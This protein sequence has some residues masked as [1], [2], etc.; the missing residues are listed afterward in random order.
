MKR[1]ITIRRR[2]ESFGRLL[3]TNGVLVTLL[4]FLAIIAGSSQ[5]LRGSLLEGVTVSSLS[6]SSSSVAPLSP[7]RTCSATGSIFQDIW[8]FSTLE[9]TFR[10]QMAA[11]TNERIELLSGPSKWSCLKDQE[12]AMPAL[13]QMAKSLPGWYVQEQ[14]PVPQGTLT[15]TMLR[16]VIWNAF[17]S[18]VTEFERVYECRLGEIASRGSIVVMDNLDYDRT[19]ATGRPTTFC[20]TE[21][22]GTSGGCVRKEEGTACSTV[23]TT[24]PQCENQCSVLIDSYQMATRL[25]PLVERMETE[26][27]HVRIAL[28]RTLATLRS[29]ETNFAIAR[30]LNCYE[31]ASVDLQNE[32]S[33]L[34]DAGSCLPRMWDIVTSLHDRKVTK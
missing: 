4:T 15:R 12:P 32:L 28:Q 17:S 29:F 34:S 18:I 10:E 26:R 19:D 9:S 20:C 30:Q 33:L 13:T 8:N 7:L 14:Y 21:A 11:V 16:P 2:I 1:S 3:R 23:E 5:F 24:D 25:K 31:R 27:A 22:S 6:G